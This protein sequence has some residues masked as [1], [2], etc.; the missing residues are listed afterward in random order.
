[1][2]FPEIYKAL[3]T[4]K[5]KT[6]QHYAVIEDGKIIAT[7]GHV[8]IYSDFLLFVSNAEE[9]EG[10]IIDSAT[11][12]ILAKKG[13]KNIICTKDGFACQNSKSR[14]DYQYA[15]HVEHEQASKNS[16]RR[17]LILPGVQTDNLYFPNWKG[18]IPEDHFENI[19]DIHEIALDVKYL[20][21]LC[22]CFSY[23][24]IEQRTTF[25]FNSN[26]QLIRV[27]NNSD[28]SGLQRAIINFHQPR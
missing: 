5:F 6:D 26:S 23:S 20:K 8:L 15:G 10:K 14:V 27:T 13:Y 18:A 28:E 7:N 17:K 19:S 4:D 3:S 11:L 22:S 24:D 9:A 2:K 21:I 16:I 12:K 25:E 1:M